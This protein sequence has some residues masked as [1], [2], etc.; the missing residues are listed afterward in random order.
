[1]KIFLTGAALLAGLALA[2]PVAAA[3]G[4]CSMTGYGSFDCDVTADGGGITFVL[5]DGQTFVFAHMA[6]GEGPG[7]LLP[8]EARPGR[9]PTELGVFRPV[10]GKD[11]CWLGDKDAIT[12]CAA[13]VQ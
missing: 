8:A 1:M 4:Q 11:G 3:P 13:L 12:F 9:Y 2:G 7:Y 6:D 10:E 5:P